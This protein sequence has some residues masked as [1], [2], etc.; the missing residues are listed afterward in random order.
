VSRAHQIL[1]GAGPYDA[2]TEQAKAWQRMLESAG[3]AGRIYADAIDPRTD[4]VDGLEHFEPAPD[5]LLFLH[6]SAYAPRL[7]PFLELPQRKLLV[8]HNVTP[9]RYLWNHHP[10]VAVLCSLGRAQLPEFAQAADVAAAVSSYNAQE[11]E[12]A[13]A[14]EVRVVP[15]LLE[16]QRFEPRGDPPAGEGPLVLCVG[17]LTPNKR[18]DLVVEAFA[19]WQRAHAPN[20]RL[21]CVGEPLSLPYLRQLQGI[22]AAA[23]ARN[24]TFAGGLTQ[25]DLNAAYASANVLL[26]LSEHEGFCVPLLEAFHFGLPVVARPVG[27]MPEVGGDAVLW[28]GDGPPDPAVVAELIELAVRDQDLHAE[29]ARRAGA[30]LVEFSHERTVK[31]ALSAVERA[32]TPVSAPSA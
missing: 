25:P 16:R 22:A 29:L 24:T 2:V 14:P 4:G 30:R 15:I 20:A 32:L 1:S 21:L 19:A 12:A 3:L 26:S 13:G 28:T 6:Y 7:R 9:A 27:G 5:D 31:K 10:R 17:R 11:L 8:H 18:H 23:R